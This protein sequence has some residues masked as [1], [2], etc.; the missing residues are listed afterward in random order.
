MNTK[1]TPGPWKVYEDERPI[2]TIWDEKDESTDDLAFMNYDLPQEQVQSNAKLI[3]AAPDLLAAID[4]L[5]KEAGQAIG[6]RD[7]K[8]HYHFMVAEEAAKR[9]IAAATS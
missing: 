3:A 9:A 7:V 8:K 4:S 6:K 2:V 1:H 5:L